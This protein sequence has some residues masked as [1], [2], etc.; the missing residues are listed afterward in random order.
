MRIALVGSGGREHALAWRLTT[1][2]HE[3]VAL[4]GNP[5]MAERAA[6]REVALGD[7]PA[8]AAACL[9]EEPALVVVGPEAP[10]AAG[11]AD[12]LRAHAVPVFGP[13]Q[14]AAQ[15]EASKAFS[16]A[17]MQSAGIPTAR[18]VTVAT[19]AELD[20]ALA[21]L[22]GAVAVKADGLAAGKGVVVCATAE[23]AREAGRRL[24]GSGRVVVEERLEGPEISIIALTDGK[25]L[26]ILPPARDHKRL[27]DGDQGPNTGGMGAVSPV[28][29]P[30][31]LLDFTR[32]S[33]LRPTLEAMRARGTP[34]S[35]ALYAGLMLTPRGPRVL[36]FNARFGDPETQAIVVAL[37][38]AVKL[39]ELLFAAATE[40]LTDAVLPTSQ[41]AA[42]VVLASA[43]YPDSPRAGDAITGLDAAR[44]AGA[45]V[46]HAGTRLEHGTLRTAGGRVLNVTA[47]GATT[48]EAREAANRAAALVRFDGLQRRT[49]V[50]ATVG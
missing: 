41:S 48:A 21:E 8:L 1:E 46:F 18:F 40:T 11:L 30:A 31:D 36:E 26:A 50:G 22:G 12:R 47:A 24:L 38:P 45:I 6:T 44:A 19:P 35:G 32:D 13:S 23:E 28:P 10:L 25:A 42:C 20:A 39:G 7:V 2:G 27:R 3:V 43:G 37:A 34:F 5:G 29:A 4:P 9:A 14:A 16:K 49:D 17:L 33:V 15:L